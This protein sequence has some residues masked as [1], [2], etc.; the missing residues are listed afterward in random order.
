MLYTMILPLNF[1]KKY[2]IDIAT[3]SILQ[4][5]PR[6]SAYLSE[7]TQPVTAPVF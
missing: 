1:H 6:L 4:M 5:G 3:A 7:V 2:E